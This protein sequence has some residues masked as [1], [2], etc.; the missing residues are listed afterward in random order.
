[1]EIELIVKFTSEWW[2]FDC[3]AVERKTQFALAC[4][5]SDFWSLFHLVS[6][7]ASWLQLSRRCQ[8]FFRGITCHSRH[9]DLHFRDEVLLHYPLLNQLGRWEAQVFARSDSGFPWLLHWVSRLISSSRSHTTWWELFVRIDDFL[10]RVSFRTITDPLV[11]LG[12]D[13]GFWKISQT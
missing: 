12:S 10:K 1:M 5:N 3:Y 13:T 9:N 4:S 11:H 6:R 8:L 2:S 7:C